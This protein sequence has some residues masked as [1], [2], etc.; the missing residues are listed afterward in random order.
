MYKNKITKGAVIK[1]RNKQK[2]EKCGKAVCFDSRKSKG[3]PEYDVC[4]ECERHLCHECMGGGRDEATKETCKDCLKER[5]EAAAAA[6]NKR[7]RFVVKIE[8]AYEV[9]AKNEVEARA[10]VENLEI[11]TGQYVEDSW[12]M[13]CAT[14]LNKDG[15]IKE[16]V[17]AGSER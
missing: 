7:Y 10:K 15:T 5:D 14:E 16:C 3:I 1:V 13:K 11:M 2:C 12:R 6:E 17:P 4:S 8:V 9:E